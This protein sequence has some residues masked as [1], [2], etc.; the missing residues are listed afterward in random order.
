MR[1]AFQNPFWVIVLVILAEVGGL[2]LWSV[3]KK[4]ERELGHR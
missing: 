2:I 3:M 4:L 1:H